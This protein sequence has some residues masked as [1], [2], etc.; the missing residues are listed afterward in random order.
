M[1]LIIMLLNS[2]MSLRRR[3]KT[4]LET[5]EESDGDEL[6]NN[7]F[8]SSSD[9]AGTCTFAYTIRTRIQ[10][11]FAYLCCIFIFISCHVYLLGYCVF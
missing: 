2:K 11:T 5:D 8:D 6:N 1:I 7:L 9:S 3:Q 4:E 10:S